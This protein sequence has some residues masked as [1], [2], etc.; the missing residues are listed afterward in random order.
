MPESHTHR[1][2]D[3]PT[4]F[5]FAFTETGGIQAEQRMKDLRSGAMVP[6]RTE[7]VKDDE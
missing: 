1:L 6:V 2:L 3:G 7:D 4:T 5:A